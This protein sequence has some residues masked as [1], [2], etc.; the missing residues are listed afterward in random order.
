MNCKSRPESHRRVHHEIRRERG[1]VLISALLLLLVATIMAVSMFRSFGMQEKIAGNLR[2]KE[3]ALHAA[4]AAEQ[5]AEYWLSSG[6]ASQP[7]SC[8]TGASSSV[9]QT[10]TNQ[11]TS[12]TTVPWTAGVSYT[13]TGMSVST[14][15]QSGTYI[16]APQFYV[17]YV[18]KGAG[19]DL[20]QIDA[21]GYG[22]T[23]NAVAVVETTYVV[24]TS[25]RCGDP[26][27]I[28]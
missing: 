21:L 25:G 22:G 5:Y 7:V 20:Y 11:L 13:P 8:T 15:P 23:V 26:T 19:G 12:P 24:K 14:T 3:R 6:S 16:G 10:C 4:Q 28:C 2:E 1:L 17:F 9:G 27:L 18:G